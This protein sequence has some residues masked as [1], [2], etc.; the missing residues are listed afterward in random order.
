MAV[1]YGVVPWFDPR[2]EIPKV[3]GLFYAGLSRFSWAI[4]VA[5]VIFACIKGYGGIVNSFLS[6]TVFM[7]LGR[8]CFCV[9][10]TSL[11]LQNIFH[12][13]MSQPIR[14]DTYTL[15]L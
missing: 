10:L 9:Y 7:P 13:R 14:Y 2:N 5:W 3:G 12:F 8:L 15:V 11:H 6:W 1:L 4:V